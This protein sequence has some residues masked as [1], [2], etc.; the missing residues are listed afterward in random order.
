[1]TTTEEDPETLS[2]WI[3]NL[4]EKGKQ[5]R[6]NA[7]SNI[8]NFFRINPPS[9]IQDEV[10]GSFLTLC[11]NLKTIQK[12]AKGDEFQKF[13]EVCQ[14]IVLSVVDS[15]ILLVDLLPPILVKASSSNE[16]LVDKEHAVFTVGFL[17]F[18][19]NSEDENF[20]KVFEVVQNNVTGFVSDEVRI[21]ALR[22][23]GML[24]SL[25]DTQYLLDNVADI[26]KSFSKLLSHECLDIRVEAGENLALLLEL[27]DHGDEVLPPKPPQSSNGS[28]Q[29]LIVE[30]QEG[31]ITA[32]Q[33]DDNLANGHDGDSWIDDLN[34]KWDSFSLDNHSKAK[35]KRDATLQRNRVQQVLNCVQNGETPLDKIILEK[36][37]IS[38]DSWQEIRLLS[39]LKEVLNDG[40]QVHLK[41]NLML[42]NALDFNEKG[43]SDHLDG[44]DLVGLDGRSYFSKSDLKKKSQYRKKN[45]N[46]R[47]AVKAQFMTND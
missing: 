9:K 30:N 38:F 8:V 15:E 25:C 23:W 19:G 28:E 21:S 39:V 1:M 47:E 34:E 17:T 26:S 31:F 44:S 46:K 4:T 36:V 14:L 13:C 40:L 12:K 41:S 7:L 11:S 24:V 37:T 22:A 3:D 35:S 43:L 18:F 16:D 2:T 6:L 42:H 32:S 10:N 27:V 45:R 5:T 20:Q 33:S 29:G